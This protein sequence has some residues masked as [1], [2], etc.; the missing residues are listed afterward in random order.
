MSD[1]LAGIPLPASHIDD[2][3]AEVMAAA[4]PKTY[5]ASLESKV[6]TATWEQLKAMARGGIGEPVE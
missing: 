3:V 4:P 6:D 5:W 1:P 2:D